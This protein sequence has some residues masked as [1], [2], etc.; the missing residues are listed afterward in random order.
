MVEE[1]EALAILS[2]ERL[3]IEAKDDQLTAIAN[4][5]G[6]RDNV[7]V[8]VAHRTPANLKKE[9]TFEHEIENERGEF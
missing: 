1:T 8:V 4:D 2:D 3:T 9:E 6:G 7:S 5:H